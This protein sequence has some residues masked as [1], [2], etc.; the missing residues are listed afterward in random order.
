MH[1]VAIVIVA[2]GSLLGS[3]F[4]VEHQES[5]ASDGTGVRLMLRAG[6]HQHTCVAACLRALET[7]MHRFV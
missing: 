2:L 1:K 7:L 5:T 4:A 3:L 6:A